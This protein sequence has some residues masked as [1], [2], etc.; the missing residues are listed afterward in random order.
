MKK[1]LSILF[2]I[3]FL[4]LGKCYSREPIDTTFHNVTTSRFIYSTKDTSLYIWLGSKWDTLKLAQPGDTVKIT[5]FVTKYQALRYK[6]KADSVIYSGY[7]TRWR[8]AHKLDSIL[9]LAKLRNDSIKLSGYFTQYDSRE[10]R[11]L[12]NADSLS[13]LKERKYQSLTDT[14]TW[15]DGLTQSGHVVK[16]DTTYLLRKATAASMYWPQTTLFKLRADSILNSGF[17]TNYRA[18]IASYLANNTWTRVYNYA[19]DLANFFKLSKDNVILPAFPLGIGSLYT[20]ADAGKITIAHMPNIRSAS[21]DTLQYS[22]KIGNVEMMKMRGIAN[23]SGGLSDTTL[24]FPKI[25]I[26]RNPVSG[27]YLKVINAQGDVKPMPIAATYQGTW[28]ATTNTPTLADG[29]GTA[30]FFYRTV[31]AGTQN[32]GSGSQTFAVN[33]DVRY[34]GSIWQMVP[35]VSYTLQAA[36]KTVLGGVKLDSTTIKY[37]GSGQLYVTK[38]DY[39]ENATHTGDATGS[40]AL[41]LATVNS[42]VGTYQ[43]IAVNGKGLVTSASNLNYRPKADH[44]S[45]S[46]LDEKAYAS[47]TGKPDLTIYRQNNDH[48]SLSTLQ[49]KN[50]S[51]LD[52][53]PDL[54]VYRQLN[55][56]DSLST[57]QERSYNS[58]TDK[59]A[60]ADDVLPNDSWIPVINYAS[61]TSRLWKL[62]KDN[63]ITPAYKLGINS[64]FNVLN[65]G[66]SYFSDIPLSAQGVGITHGTGV[67]IGNTDAIKIYGVGNSSGGIDTAFVDV[68]TLLVR[69]GAAANKIAMSED[70]RGKIRWS[71]TKYL[72][73]LVANRILYASATNEMSQL[74]LGTAGQMMRSGGTGTPI[75]ST[76]TWPNSATAGKILIGDGTNIVLSTPT[77]PNASATFG[78]MIK[79]DGTNWVAS[80]ETYAAPGT[81]GYVMVSNGTNWTSSAKNLDWDKYNQWDGG[82]TGLVQ[83][84]AITSLGGTTIGKSMFQLTNPSATTFP[85]L[86]AD[87]TVSALTAADFRTAI[88]A[89]TS[90]TVGTVTSVALS[91]P[92]GLSISGSPITS[93]GT[94]ALTLTTGYVIPTTTEQTNWG[95]A[96]TN[97]ITSLTTTGSSG[98]STLSSNT[99][100]IPNYTLLGLGGQPLATVLTNIQDSLNNRYRRGDTATVILSRLRAGHDYQPKGSYLVAAD[101]AGKLD[102]T[103][104]TY[105]MRANWNAAYGWGN[106]A[107]NFGTTAGTIAQGNDS[108][109]SNGQTAYG[110]GN[111]AS[112]G[113]LTTDTYWTG[114]ATNLVAA[115]GRTSLGLGSAAVLNAAT[116]NTAST[117][118][119][120]DGSGNV[121]LT[122]DI[123]TTSD[124]RLKKNMKP[125]DWSKLENLDKINWIQYTPIFK[126]D[127]IIKYGTKAQ[128]L[129][130]IL[131]QFVQTA[132]DSARTKSVDYISLLIAKMIEMEGKII[133]RDEKIESLEKRIEK[134]E[135]KNKW[136]TKQMI[137]Q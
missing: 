27:Y 66:F 26:T 124:I 114:T 53:K 2:L 11:K 92:T 133:Q 94:L 93:S 57:L 98:A 51:S 25:R 91:T 86:N 46:T 72:F 49:E 31:V 36:T 82:S 7:T 69:T 109:I 15:G 74:P 68:K 6:E 14:T 16:A 84:T 137:I 60:I 19:G 29:T 58:L 30:D 3:I 48:D 24:I 85:R 28:N 67:R 1:L 100:N 41:T 75:W 135:R 34:N 47:L 21:G 4:M 78:K 8:L 77:F 120:R 18:S 122:G 80:T 38:T 70:S 64:F 118:I 37:N 131:P 107:S 44:D 10:Y 87:N 89:G 95:T 116:A 35:A 88:G 83:A 96:Y 12:N 101:I 130:K 113:Y 17:Y 20:V 106:W 55:N 5:D 63:I 45:L 105:V 121:S 43:G 42:N 54:T 127:S 59:P 40:G 128:E 115:T 79:S 56:H 119:Q 71:D 99:L 9:G 123:C 22:F 73:S 65:P 108:R 76:P 62:S 32:L 103:K 50:Y 132:Q 39:V 33:S 134:L 90:S 61:D 117:V 112:A 102:T 81:S 111:H 129:E 125:I 13:H 110:W 52:G 126:P 23:G 97:R 136:Q 104:A